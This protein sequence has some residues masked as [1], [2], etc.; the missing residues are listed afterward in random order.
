MGKKYERPA[1]IKVKIAD[2]SSEILKLSKSAN[3]PPSK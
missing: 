3:P 1:E 2:I